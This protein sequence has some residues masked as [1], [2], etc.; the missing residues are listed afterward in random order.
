MSLVAALALVVLATS[1]A[2]PLPDN[3]RADRVVLEKSRR[4]LSLYSGDTLLT[5]YKVALGGNPEGHKEQQGDSRT[6]EGNY[7][8]DYRNPQ[9]SYHLSLHISYPNEDD[10]R[11]A[12]E[13]GVS[14]GGDIFVHGLPPK[15]A[16]AG[17]LHTNSDWTDGCIAISNEE[18][19]EKEYVVVRCLDADA[20]KVGDFVV[21]RATTRQYLSPQ[22]LETAR[23]AIRRVVY[24][25]IWFDVV[26]DLLDHKGTQHPPR[27]KNARGSSQQR[28]HRNSY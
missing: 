25:S 20:P 11:R 2:E 8:I 19:E 5:T 16:W 27:T 17:A 12:V 28:I 1:H 9:S 15:F 24:Y 13:R 26:L 10:K 22:C 23:R 7:S 3:A 21:A 6:P 4:L 18:I 14:P